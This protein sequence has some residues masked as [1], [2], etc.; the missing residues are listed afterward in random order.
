MAYK[1]NPFTGKLDI[2]GTT[3]G[4]GGGGTVT[5]ITAGTGLTGGTITTSGTIAIDSNVVVK[6][7]NNNISAN[8]FFNNLATITASGTQVVLTA[9]SAPVY[10]V[11]G[12][13]GQTIKLPDATTLTKGTIFSFNNNQS[14]GAILVNNNSNTL[15]VSIPSGAYV[16]V[17]LLD[18]ATAAGTWDRHDQSPANVSWSTNTFDYP[19]SIT[20]ATWNGNTVAANRGGT[21]QSSPFVAGGIAY[22]STTSALGVTPIGTAGQVL[23][24]AGAAAPTWTTPATITTGAVDNAI[25]RAD[26]TGGATL[27]N[28]GLIIEDTITSFAVTGVA[29]TDIIT[30]TGSAFANDQPV[31]FTTLTGGNGLITTTNYYVINV[32]GATFQVSTSVGG[33]A[34]L[35]TTDITSGTLL[36]GHSPSPNVTISEN[37]TATN[38]D[39]VLTPK[40]T[41]AFIL[42]PKQNNAASGGDAR[43]IRAVDLQIEKSNAN[44]V[45]SGINSVIGGGRNNRNTGNLSVVCGGQSNTN[46]SNYS[47]ICGGDGNSTASAYGG[48]LGVICGG[49]YNYN[50]S[51]QAFIGGGCKNNISA[52]FGVICGGGAQGNNSGNNVSG[53]FGAI[54]GG[55]GG[56]ADRTGMQ[57][58]AS[59]QFSNVYPFS[60]GIGDAQRARFVLR[61]KTTTNTGVEMALDGGTSY[62]GIPS[63]K[64]IAMTINISG[65]KSDGTAVAHYLRQYAV[66][67]ISATAVS[68]QVYAPVTI[69]SDNA[70]GTTI[71]LSV[72]DADD[73][74]RILVTGI[75]SETWRWVA[76]VD[77]VE[78]AYGL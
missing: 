64:V 39:L 38:S 41:G 25:L 10:L 73:T 9:A 47:V 78:I 21:G 56:R 72:N 4:G 71:A 14:S 68:S 77:A 59:G 13:G 19:G 16:T 74:L 49:Q 48:F 31:R 75:A 60:G 17:V 63:G 32:S 34:S 1:F 45:A 27:Q 5:S 67:N 6:D 15:V 33:A 12:S 69:G 3:G 24:S 65:V 43:G 36:N 8:A 46:L 30:A 62:L 2:S 23:T 70:A 11:S 51:R 26:G 35:F 20:S 7:A 53:T 42:G 18:N 76:S 61:C 55:N 50:A 58:H 44:Q 54:L 52:D 29:S 66:K 37:T 40:G 28:S 57:A 22:G